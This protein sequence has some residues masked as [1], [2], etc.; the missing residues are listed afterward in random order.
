MTEKADGSSTTAF[1]FKGNFGL[2]SRNLELEKNL[3]NGYWK[4]VEKYKVED[5]L[6]ENIA[7]QWETCGPG[8]QSNPMGLK[9]VDGFMFSAYNIHEKRYLN[10]RE[11][12]VLSI[13]MQFPMVRVIEWGNNFISCALETRGEGVYK[14][15]KQREGVVIRS[16]E[17]F[18]H[19]PISFKVINL[20]YEK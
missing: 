19:A 1:K 12:R 6:P 2:C 3:D 20:N 9:E 4:V 16:Q 5:K 14:N 17:N 15:G 8:I 7:I 18:G 10:F 13:E 11:L